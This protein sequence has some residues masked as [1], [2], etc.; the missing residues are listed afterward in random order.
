M[1]SRAGFPADWATR[2]EKVRR[3]GKG[4]VGKLGFSFAR[5]V[6][7]VGVGFPALPRGVSLA[8]GP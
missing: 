1:P 3:R 5:G 2:E 8:P 4:S 6:D 7:G